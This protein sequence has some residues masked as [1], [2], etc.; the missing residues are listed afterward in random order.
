MDSAHPIRTLPQIGLLLKSARKARGLS[1]SQLAL[2]VGV[3]QSRVSDLEL[4]ASQMT[5]AQLMAWCSALGL[6]VSLCAPAP[7]RPA[8]DW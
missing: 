3:G 2:R 7:A 4:D 6:E 8:E 1:Q 5:L